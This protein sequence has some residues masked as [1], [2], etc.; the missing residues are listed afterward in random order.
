[1]TEEKAKKL[2]ELEIKPLR[3][4]FDHI[5]DA[6]IYKTAVKRCA[7]YG[8]QELS[9]YILYNSEAF[10]G[11]GNVYKSDT[12]EELYER[13]RI[14][15]ELKE[16][17]NNKLSEHKR[18]A[19]FSFPMRYIPLTE[20][21]RGFVCYPNWNIKYLRA[22]QVMMMPTQGKGV[23]GRGFFEADFGKDVDEFKKILLMPE[24]VIMSRGI[25][26][27]IKLGKDETEDERE[28]RRKK[29]E[30]NKEVWNE[31]E[32][33]YGLLNELKPAFSQLITENIFSYEKWQTL[34]DPLL[35]KLFIHH[36]S[37]SKLLLLIN[38]I[39]VKADLELLF[40]YC[41]NE[42]PLLFRKISRYVYQS[43]ISHIFLE[44]FIK[45][46]GEMGFKEL[47]RKW[48]DDK[49]NN[50][51][52]LNTLDKITRPKEWDD[53]NVDILRILKSYFQLNCLSKDEIDFCKEAI[54]DFNLQ[55]VIE[56]L[57]KNFEQFAKSLKHTVK[58][59]PGEKELKRQV[60]LITDE[61]YKQL[62]LF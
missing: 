54:Q 28:L 12:P 29:W 42:F 21:K 19:F 6:E 14:T 36:L 59:S 38:Q 31:W 27:E 17:I 61:I 44:A 3:I 51:F 4:A 15:L 9:N 50:D 41:T 49:C 47:I 35:K 39:D 30:D 2:S 62:T 56:I 22:I 37:N 33:L 32:R 25:F 10:S 45:L 60:G 57:K 11:K 53:F 24:E 20:K 5:E 55:E 13:L 26:E 52:F 40:C 18:I 1:M 34:Y 46:F 23:S 8:V 16:E 48:F 7:K 58:G 43:K